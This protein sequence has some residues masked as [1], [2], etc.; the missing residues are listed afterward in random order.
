MR[1]ETVP[2]E[3]TTIPPMMPSLRPANVRHAQLAGEQEKGR[4]AGRVAERA[5]NRT[6]TPDKLLEKESIEAL[7]EAFPGMTDGE[8]KAVLRH[9][10]SNA[11]DVHQRAG[12]TFTFT[13]GQP[14]ASQVASGFGAGPAVGRVARLES[15]LEDVLGRTSRR[16]WRAPTSALAPATARTLEDLIR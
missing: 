6:K 11:K 5:L 2:A 4:L 10:L 1:V 16:Q 14:F 7:R 15:L 3:A 12:G 13:P 8:R 9:I